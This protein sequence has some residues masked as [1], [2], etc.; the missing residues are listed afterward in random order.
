M[1][2]HPRKGPQ[3]DSY[4]ETNPLVAKWECG[5]VVNGGSFGN[6]G[7]KQMPIV[8][9]HVREGRSSSKKDA[10]FQFVHAT[11]MKPLISPKMTVRL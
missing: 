8:Q 2:Y 6:H 7:V 9:V 1:Q 4:R 11:L 10:L 3:Q 5:A